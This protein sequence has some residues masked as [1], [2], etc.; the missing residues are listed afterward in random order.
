MSMWPTHDGLTVVGLTLPREVYLADRRGAESVYRDVLRSTPE[1]AERVRPGRLAS[2]VRGA[3]N[4]R[5]F[6]RGSHGPGWVLAGDAGYQTDP[7]G[8]RGIS[9]AFTDAQNLSSSL[10]AGL[11]GALPME[12]SL[13][14][15]EM[16]RNAGRAAAFEFIC[17]QASL[18]SPDETFARVLRGVGENPEAAVELVNVFAGSRRIEEFFAPANLARLAARSGGAPAPRPRAAP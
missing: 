12:R 1:L 4:L 8:A 6:Y 9:D 17:R 18:A 5:N 2:P 14:R 15:Y 10:D 13:A 3:A 16:R 7:I 11:T